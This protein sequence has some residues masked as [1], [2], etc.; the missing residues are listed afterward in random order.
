MEIALLPKKLSQK[1]LVGLVTKVVH[2]YIFTST[3]NRSEFFP[4]IYVSQK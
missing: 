2:I 4:Q 1:W 3:A